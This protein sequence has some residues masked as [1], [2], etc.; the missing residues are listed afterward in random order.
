MPFDGR[1]L[2]MYRVFLAEEAAQMFLVDERLDVLC[3][4]LL[5]K[6]FEMSRDFCQFFF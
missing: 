3:T 1:L 5:A 2:D 6:C 4:D